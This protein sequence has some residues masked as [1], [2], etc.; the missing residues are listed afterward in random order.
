MICFPK[1][2]PITHIQVW[3]TVFSRGWEL[4]EIYRCAKR[5]AN[6]PIGIL[7]RDF[8]HVKILTWLEV[9]EE[10]MSYPDEVGRRGKKLNPFKTL[11]IKGLQ[12]ACSL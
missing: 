11:Q 1:L 8:D 3:F 4:I 7:Q 9:E 6:P 5:T 2:R 12:G 10:K